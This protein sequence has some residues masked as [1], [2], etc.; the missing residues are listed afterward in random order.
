MVRSVAIALV[1]AV[2]A[3]SAV[4]QLASLPQCGQTCISNMMNIA[5]TKFNCKPNDVVCYCTNA[6]F[7]HGV[8]D[9]SNESCPNPADAQKVIAF[10]TQ[11]CQG[12]SPPRR[13]CFLLSDK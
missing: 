2:F 1:S 9:C 8:R 7:G 4:A 6:D 10:G 3:S 5:N 11:Y 12:M 13:L